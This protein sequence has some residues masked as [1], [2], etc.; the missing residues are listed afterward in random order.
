MK[1]VR[2]LVLLVLTFVALAAHGHPGQVA[3]EL[4]APGRTCTG[5]AF[6]GQK[7]WVADHGLD[8]LLA[9]D[10]KTGRLVGRLPSPGYRPAGLAFDGQQ[11]WNVD[12][13]EAKL[14]RL[15][16]T[17]GLVTRVIPS[18]VAVPQALAWDGA[19]LWV[20]DDAT[21]AIHRVEPL[22]GTTIAEVPFPGASVSGLAHD[23]RYLWVADRLAD[24]LYAVDPPSGEVV[25]SLAAPGPY[26]SGLGFDGHQLVAVDYQTDR[27]SLVVTDDDEPVYR[28]DPREDWVVF[29]N[30]V[31]N[32]GPDA[33]PSVNVH[34]AVP[35]ARQSQDLLSGPS[36]EP[37]PAAIKTDRWDQPVAHFRFSDLAAGARATVRMKARV[38][39]WTV[40]HV[41]YP[42]KVSGLWKIPAEIRRR[43]LAD[44]PKYSID[45]PVIQKAV[46]E[47]VGDEK[48]PYWI[49]RKIYAFVHEKMHYE[50]VGGWDVAPKVLKRGSGSCSE[51]SFV[52][53]AMCRAA[54]LPA[55]YV[56][57]LVIRRDDA[58]YDD[59][60][61]RW[62]EVYLP[63]YGWVPV[64]PSRGDK[65]SQAER[66]DAFG[67]VTG[68]F[69]ITTVGGG[70][71][72]LLDWNYNANLRYTCKGR[73][74][75]EVESIAEWSPEDP[76]GSP[77]QGPKPGAAPE[78]N[79]RSGGGDSCGQP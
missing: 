44:E 8:A 5:L 11:L 34:L 25:A 53:I 51:Y 72:D 45:H 64:D 39:A 67:T 68:D 35:A 7:I 47:A 77:D 55:R 3:A 65:K 2:G 56:G 63:P 31:R 9:V 76:A 74:K 69:L 29:T 54:G 15:R 27:I 50:M 18:P 19:A 70:G 37:A 28:E 46:A 61:H 4:P 57:A 49:A 23:G 41:V 6:D 73:C 62:V 52:F 43:Y 12:V 22:D 75:V 20:S 60:F 26:T 71:S 17:D 13:M 48:R 33:L 10:P 38:R 1:T 42:H 36:F 66:A 58:S 30:Q 21:H 32:F 59:V 14:Y 24:M 78:S 79:K 16:P 40:H